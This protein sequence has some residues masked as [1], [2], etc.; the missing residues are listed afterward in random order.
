MTTA[1]SIK[2]RHEA[3]QSQWLADVVSKEHKHHYLRYLPPRGKVDYVLVAKMTSI[4]KR[5]AEESDPGE[6]SYPAPHLNLLI[7]KGD[8]ILNYGAHRHLCKTGET[9]YLTDLGK[10]AIPPQQARGKLEREEFEFWYTKLLEELELVAKPTA[11]VVPVGRATWN[12][13]QK[14]KR[15]CGFSFALAG[16]ILHWSRQTIGAAQIASTLFP[17][18][19]EDFRET[20]SWK[21]LYKSTEEIF[22][23][24]GLSQYMD[25]VGKRIKDEFRD[26]DKYYMFTYEKQM[27]LLRPHT[28]TL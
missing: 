28:S 22:S 19:W 26:S 8:L 21:D 27:P 14:K 10:C 1:L 15:Q 7:S 16:P 20:T 25:T 13:L 17:S 9:Y 2:E 5:K 18:E 4:G 12:F 23:E 11:T 6:L 3:L 24:A